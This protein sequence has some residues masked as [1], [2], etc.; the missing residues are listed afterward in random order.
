MINATI[1]PLTF[2]N[3]LN[4]SF[5]KLSQFTMKNNMIEENKIVQITQILNLQ[6]RHIYIFL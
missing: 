2:V 5:G 3:N 4:I 1:I 6:L